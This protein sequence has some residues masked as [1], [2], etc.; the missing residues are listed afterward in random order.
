MPD[1]EHIQKKLNLTLSS[2]PRGVLSLLALLCACSADVVN[3]GEN[4]DALTAPASSRC[5]QS[6]TLSGDAI[7][8][9]QEQLNELEG[10]SIIAGDLAIVPF[11]AA[12]LRPLH[13]LKEVT[14]LLHV[15]DGPPD[16]PET[17]SARNV[18]RIQALYENGW[19]S[20]LEGLESL[21]RVG[22]L[23]LVGLTAE[24][25]QPLTNLRSLTDGGSIL[26]RHCPNLRDLSGLE[27]LTG[28][29]DLY[30]SCEHLESLA[31]LRLPRQLNSI[32]LTGARLAELGPQSVDSVMGDV[33]ISGTALGNLDEL[34]SLRYVGGSLVIEHSPALQNLNGLNGLE[35]AGTLIVRANAQL[36]RLPEYSS[37]V[38]LQGIMIYDNPV[39]V[40]LASFGALGGMTPELS[41]RDL[42]M[43]R[44][45]LIEVVGNPELQTITVPALF[46][47]G[48]YV[49]IENN[50]KL[51]RLDLAQLTSID[52]LS[53]KNNPVLGAVALGALG[54][55]DSLEV[56]D[57]PALPSS[58]FD[59][60]RTFETQ[61]SG[62]AAP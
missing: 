19:L 38:R 7:I 34:T 24:N 54:R 27:N 59:G 10:C 51:S 48:S 61:M 62:N 2:T 42:L 28:I 13:A 58:S 46:R 16:D 17:A 12:D 47:S 22:G 31:P 53:I 9:D 40:E 57:N 8:K 43:Y 26:L 23:G 3:V 30:V 18:N 45:D 55:V 33:S 49:A 21:E 14:G 6:S 37:L 1:H 41:A 52:G 5:Q 36:Q 56:L 11:A 35:V 20:S 60:V 25:L 29:V 15:Y 50:A 44:P 39:L 4:E 32:H